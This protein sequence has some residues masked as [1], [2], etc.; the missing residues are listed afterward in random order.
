MS[1]PSDLEIQV[2]IHQNADHLI[3]SLYTG[4]TGWS[5]KRA[6]L[7]LKLR[8][9]YTTLSENP[10]A[11]LAF[12][13]ILNQIRSQ[14][15]LLS[16]EPIVP[17]FGPAAGNTAL[18][19]LLH[20]ARLSERWV[21]PVENWQAS[22]EDTAREQFASLVQHLFARYPVPAFFETAFFEGFSGAGERH[23][24]WFLHLGDGRNLRRT[25]D[26]PVRLTE[27]MAHFALLA[28]ADSTVVT[29]LRYGQ[30]RGLGGTPEL[31]FALADSRLRDLLPDEPFWESVIHFFINSA[32]GPLAQIAP[33]VDFV[34]CQRYG[35]TLKFYVDGTLDLSDAPEP[36]FSM[37]GR[38]RHALKA[39]MEEWHEG[40]ARDAK[41]PKSSWEASGLKPFTVE[42][43]DPSG[44]LCEW[45]I[46]ELRDTQALMAE[47]REQRHC[48]FTYANGCKNGGTSIWSL[49]VRGVQDKAAR[50][51][52][53]IE[54]NLHKRAIVQVRGR[55]NLTPSQFRAA[56]RMGTG[57]K[58]LRFW[59]QRE[60]L[61]LAC[62]C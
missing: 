27:K 42:E 24:R 28:P 3:R 55:C 11:S 29:A 46:V 17:A 61:S 25:P 13:R 52:L 33:L 15:K 48:V 43:P 59:A 7:E 38:R 6:A 12:E 49:R 23:R 4:K 57:R 9:A 56:G 50:R 36:D 22:A 20:L 21:R 53:T 39:K 26:L 58:L 47:G 54:V 62:G 44:V 41:R 30:V 10:E 34:F 60:K 8:A 16:I 51:L 5:A 37:K 1:D 18:D 45:T 19:A 40:L 32:D 2:S 31:A 14:T 35:D